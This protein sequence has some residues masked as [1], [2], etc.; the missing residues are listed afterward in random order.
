MINS[1][2]FKVPS[3]TTVENTSFFP[4]FML[5]ASLFRINQKFVSSLKNFQKSIKGMI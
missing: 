4:L 3:F 1:L 2:L 5:S